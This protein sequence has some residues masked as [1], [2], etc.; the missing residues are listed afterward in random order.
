[1]AA[2]SASVASVQLRR[3][4]AILLPP[5]CCYRLITTPTPLFL[6]VAVAEQK[7]VPAITVEVLGLDLRRV[8]PLERQFQAGHSKSPKI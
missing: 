3:N 7:V 2:N 8:A 1:M 6:L 5:A 4:S